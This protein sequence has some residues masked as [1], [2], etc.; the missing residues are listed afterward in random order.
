MDGN[1]RLTVGLATY[2]DF[3]GVYFTVQSLRLHHGEALEQIEILVV[4]N[5]PRSPHGQAV[6]E[7]MK[8]VPHGR[9][10]PNREK[11]GTA[12]RNLVFDAAQTPYVLCLDC[13]VL[14]CPGALNRLLDF[15]RENPLSGDLLQGPLLPDSFAPQKIVTH[16]EPRWDSCMFGAWGTDPRGLHPDAP[17]FEIPM[18]GLGLFA[19]RK[20][21]WLRFNERFRG[22]GAEEGY[23]HEKYRQAGRRTLCLPFLRWLHRFIRPAGANYPLKLQDRIH[24]YIVGWLELGLDTTPILDHFQHWGGRERWERMR[25]E[26]TRQFAAQ[27]G[28]PA[29]T[30]HAA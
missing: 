14:L 12:V 7:F 18:H 15:Y 20:D 17:P 25:A 29:V 21:A 2:D 23:I 8:L 16:M 30:R 26:L 4:D 19:C 24:N 5:N 11:V 6:A 13:H 3:D 27:A 10:L 1:K 22:F 9:Y 28:S